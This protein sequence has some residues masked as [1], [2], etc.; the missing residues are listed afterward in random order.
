MHRS[1]L[2]RMA[3]TAFAMA[4][5]AGATACAQPKL[6]IIG[7]DTHDWGKVSPGKLTTVVQV[8]NSG[9]ADLKISD[10]RPGCGCTVAP[11]DK[12]L[13]KPGETANINIS[14]DVASKTGPVE[15][16]VTITSNDSSSPAA[17]SRMLYLK[18]DVH[19]AVTIAPMQYMLVNDGKLGVES[20]AS[21][22]TIK[23]TGDKPFTIEPPKLVDGANIAVRFDMKGT[24]ELKP[25]E[26][27]VVKAFVTPKDANGLNGT[28][29]MKTSTSEMPS[30]DIPINGTMAGLS[31]T[32]KSSVTP[33]V[34]TSVGAH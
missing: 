16:V 7:G 24:R 11:I 20:V 2:I 10:V 18:A 30:I 9:N 3:T 8:K 28:I 13:L 31:T 27:F 12:N 19:R 17:T 25:G 21:P 29:T 33:Q 14:L 5:V 23:N 4:C 1:S 32:G 26:E 6:E 15:K 22:V 34:S